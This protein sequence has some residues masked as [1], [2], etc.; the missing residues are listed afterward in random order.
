[1]EV[2]TNTGATI[3]SFSERAA[4][5]RKAPGADPTSTDTMPMELCDDDTPTGSSTAPICVD[6]D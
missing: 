3:R 5:K 1:V 6:S 4:R 2:D